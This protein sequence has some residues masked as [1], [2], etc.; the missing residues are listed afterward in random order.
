MD[1]ISSIPAEAFW[2][3]VVCFPGFFSAMATSCVFLPLLF[4]SRRIHRGDFAIFRVSFHSPSGLLWFT[5]KKNHF[6]SYF[7]KIPQTNDRC[8][9]VTGRRPSHAKYKGLLHGF[10]QVWSCLFVEM[11]PSHD[12]FR[13]SLPAFFL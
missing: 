10:G 8:C 5:L 7:S 6:D 13:I 3:F 2:C 11:A 12:F 1:S 4:L 9:A